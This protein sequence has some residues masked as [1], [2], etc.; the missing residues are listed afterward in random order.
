MDLVLGIS[1]GGD[2]ISHGECTSIVDAL[3]R[4]E[5][6]RAQEDLVLREKIV[7]KALTDLVATENL[8]T[9]FEISERLPVPQLFLVEIRHINTTRHEDGAGDISNGFEGSLDTIENGLHNTW[10]E[11]DGEGSLG[12]EHGVAN[13]EAGCIFVAL[14]GS[15]AAFELDNLA[16]EFVPTD[17]DQLVHLGAAHVFSDHEGASDLEDLSVV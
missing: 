10:S 17:L 14:E 13:S 12:P 4:T 6:F 7:L 5:N 9:G 1:I 2:N 11:F 3:E 8:V 16:D 15:S